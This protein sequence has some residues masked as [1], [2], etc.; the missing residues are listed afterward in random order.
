VSRFG[1]RA[2]ALAVAV[3]AGFV[4]VAGPAASGAT[5]AERLDGRGRVTAPA[6]RLNPPPRQLT[7]AATGDILVHSPLWSQAARNA[8]GVGYD[9]APMFAEIAPVI[10]FADLAICHLETPIAPVGQAL[11]TSPLYGVPV[12][13]THAIASAGYDRC[14]TA[15]NHS[16]DRGVA[17]IDRT[18][19]ALE[20]VGVQQSGMARTRSET[21]PK[22]VDVGG[23]AVSHLSYTYGFNGVYIAPGDRW[24]SSLIDV[25][26]IIA[27]G[28]AA[29][30]RGAE[31]VVLSLH[32]GVEG[33]S[34]PSAEQRR[35]ADAVTASGAVDLIIGHH[36]HV[37]QPIEQINGVWVVFGLG[38]FLSNM[39]TG[40]RFSPATQDGAIVD[41]TVTMQDNA[42]APHGVEAV[43]DRPRVTP[44]WVDK[45]TGWVIRDVLAQLA[46][47][48]IPVARRESLINALARTRAVVGQFVPR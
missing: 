31:L 12:Q 4:V 22:V 44:T 16:F 11:S 33:N 15:S 32:W 6:D 14:S 30:Q 45:N 40:Q 8:G 46:D 47:P 29:R 43:I 5:V 27:D 20:S 37:L 28:W 17:G 25:D 38:N 34:Q 23:V 9:F 2:F 24:R 1:V 36:A 42:A 26:Q 39:P 19:S 13:V 48:T 35:V 10:G 18:V 41:F 3:A 21:I 7:I